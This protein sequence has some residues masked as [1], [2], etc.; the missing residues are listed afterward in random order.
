MDRTRTFFLNKGVIPFFLC[1]AFAF[2]GTKAPPGGGGSPW[3]KLL[4]RHVTEK[5]FVDYE[6]MK[7]DRDLL[8]QAL[9]NIK[10]QTP[11]SASS[12][13]ERIAYWIN[14]YNAF[15]IELVLEH[16]PISS[17]NDIEDPFDRKF[18]EIGGRT[19]SLNGIEKG[20]LLKDF[21]DPRIHY[22][23]N[24]ASIS[25]PPLRREPYRAD[26]L[27]RQLKEQAKRF[28]NDPSKN[29]LKKGGVRISK[30]YDWYKEDFTSNGSLIEHLNR[31]AKG[32]KV[33]KDA[34]I[35]YMAYDWGLNQKE[36]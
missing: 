17:I 14:A 28:V 36:R 19:Y 3:S 7:K 31:Y 2:S 20:I 24:C 16:Y 25:C 34:T 30:L 12:R 35:G 15:T 4:D 13:E 23:V 6:G 27:D 11:G 5:G 9:K 26:D 8:D 10:E 22:A 18:I 21:D 29:R 1:F 33:R 32:V